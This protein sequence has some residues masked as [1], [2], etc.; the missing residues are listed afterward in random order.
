[1][2]KASEHL[3]NAVCADIRHCKCNPSVIIIYYNCKMCSIA[4]TQRMKC[5][6]ILI[7]HTAFSIT[8]HEGNT[9]PACTRMLLIFP[10]E[11]IKR[12]IRRYLERNGMTSEVGDMYSDL[13]VLIR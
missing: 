6:I 11:F 2:H 5:A 7:I 3:L 4:Y 1:M 13:R 8:L 10:L 12:C 9:M